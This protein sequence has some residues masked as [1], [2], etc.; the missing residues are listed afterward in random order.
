[1]LSIY[2][3]MKYLGDNPPEH[4][5]S[6]MENIPQKSLSFDQEMGK[7]LINKLRKE[8]VSL[9]PT[10]KT[11][12]YKKKKQKKCELE[13]ECGGKRKS[14]LLPRF[15][16]SFC[17]QVSSKFDRYEALN[18]LT[19]I[20]TTTSIKKEKIENLPIR[21][22]ESSNSFNCQSC[23]SKISFLLEYR[24]RKFDTS[25]FITPCWTALFVAR[26]GYFSKK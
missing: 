12:C 11:H 14:E 24:L 20:E 18:T 9:S 17:A 25:P 1:M 6:T 2:V 7:R 21:K 19:M 22:V 13:S 5:L 26:S 23:F 10:L 16:F 8:G 4:S 15:A 3:S